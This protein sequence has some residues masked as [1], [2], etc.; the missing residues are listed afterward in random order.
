M[1]QKVIYY[2]TFLFIFFLTNEVFS[3]PWMDN[4]KKDNPPQIKDNYN[5]YDIQKSFYEYVSGKDTTKKGLGWKQFK[6]WE[7]FWSQRVY[8]SGNFPA[9]DQ[10]YNELKS[11]QRV[12]GVD[13]NKN[14]IQSAANWISLGPST[15]PGGYAGLGRI[16][17]VQ[18]DPNNS[19]T[20][21]IGAASG[22]LWKSTNG[23]TTWSTTTDELG[24]IGVTDVIVDKNN[25]NIVY[26]ATGDGDA[27]DAYSIGVMKSTDGGNTWNTTGLNWTQ[28]Q[29]RTISRLL[30]DPSSSNILYAGGSSGI[31]KTTDAGANWTQ[32]FS[33]MSVKDMEFK[34]GNSSVIYASGVYIYRSTDAGANWSQLTNGLPSSAQRVALGVSPANS[35]Y[36]YALMSNSSSGFLGLYR[37]TDS[38]NSWTTQATTPNL[39]GWNSNGGDSG[40]QGW[41]DLCIAVDQSNAN[42][43]Y[44]GGVNIWKSTDGGVNW[45]INAHWWGD[46]VPAVHADQHN[47]WFAPGTNRLYNGCDGGVY[48]TTNGGTNWN[49]IGSGLTIT[50][51][52]RIG[53]SQTNQNVWIAGAQD[54]G[55]KN[56]VSSTWQDVIGGDGMEC[57]VDN[58]TT[59][60]QYG[61]L[62]YGEIL[63]STDG[64]NN[65]YDWVSPSSFS[66]EAGSWV[67]PYVQ[68][69]INP[70]TIFVG[71]RNIYKTT[72]RG[73]SWTKIS[74]FASTSTL[75][76]LDVDPDNG[77]FIY[78]SHGTDLMMSTDGGS[79][80]NTKTLPSGL[81]LTYLA[82]KNTTPL[83]IYGAFS[84]Y[85]SGNKVFYSTDG[86][87]TWNNLSY[88]LPNLPANTIMY[89][90]NTSRLYVG[91]DIGVYYLDPGQTTWKDFN[92]N[93][94]NVVV[95]EIDYQPSFAKM[96]IATYGR[97]IWE[98]SIFSGNA[99]SLS[100]PLNNATYVSQIPTLTWQ[101]IDLADKYEIMIADNNQF[102]NPIV[103]RTDVV[104][105]SYT[106]A[107]YEKLASN[108]TYYWKVRAINDNAYGLWSNSVAPTYIFTTAPDLPNQIALL[109][110]ANNSINIAINGNVT[111]QSDPKS[112]T[113]KLQIATD[114]NFTNLIYNQTGIATTSFA[115][116]SLV[117][118]T[119][120]YWRVCG[121]NADG[122]GPWSS[123]WNF[124]TIPN[125]PGQV[126]LLTPANNSINI[127]INGNV[128]WQAESNSTTYKMQIATDANFTN[129]V[130]NQTGIATTSFAYSSLVNNTKYYWRVL[131]TNAGGDGPWSAVWNFT[132]IQQV[133]A[134][135]TL[136]LPLSASKIYSKNVTLEWNSAVRAD[137]YRLQVA[138]DA[139]FTNILYNLTDLTTLTNPLSNLS[140]GTYY[141]RVLGTNTG[142]DGPWSAVWNFKIEVLIPTKVVLTSPADNSVNMPTNTALTWQSATN[143]TTYDLLV[144]TDN[145]F[146]NIV[147]NQTGI[148]ATNYN[149]TGLAIQKQYFWKVR[150]VHPSNAGEWSDAWSFATINSMFTLN[151]SDKITCKGNDVEIGTKDEEGNIITATGGS[152]NFTYTWSPS[153]LLHNANTGNPTYFN[154]NT[155][156]AF[157]VTVKDNVSGI[158]KSG[159]VKVSISNGPLIIMPLFK[160][161]VVGQ[162]INLDNQVT[163]ISGG[164]PPYTR[165]WQDNQGNT[166]SNVVVTPPLGLNNYFLTATDLNSCSATKKLAIIVTNHKD[167]I[168][169]DNVALSPQGN[170]AIIAFPNPVAN[171]LNFYTITQEDMPL[172]VQ[173]SNLDGKNVYSQQNENLSSK[174]TVDLSNLSAGTYFL[175][176]SN[177]QE[178]TVFKFIKK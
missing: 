97:G 47:L 36:I 152:G 121:T 126:T 67:T 9:A 110:P 15:S 46:G 127:A 109:T 34:P 138:T 70:Q 40:G 52:Y 74:S 75:N 95:S 57:I 137:K 30:M 43:I 99:V 71:Y 108:K 142:G 141:W 169:E 134:M 59:T 76:V 2:L 81:Y 8:P 115:Y 51:F 37:S 28:A 68:H 96:K 39:L 84:G 103:H 113:Y 150:G 128:T 176:V 92:T 58:S 82:I 83:T 61:E 3:Q 41:Y 62:Y 112:I 21:Y 90:K 168:N 148:T 160:V 144:A 106:V 94:P 120:Y 66:N 50:Q 27:G 145:N 163:S 143:A 91:T 13:K 156:A 42:I 69:P 56:Y 63:R 117:N 88:N 1:K 162:S 164:T 101:A 146:T 167:L 4:L 139:N 116:S 24:S 78:A 111:W 171:I 161:I 35:N 49:W 26:I 159:T 14:K 5:F 102:D 114:A 154:P 79:T 32:I 6:R 129:I 10:T 107:D 136:K 147:Q 133:P 172:N 153:N 170:I 73:A 22:G 54:N 25:S 125:P 130:Y 72:D 93:L 86:G 177:G 178:Q 87:S 16:N 60:Y 118:N 38:G 85:S 132:T 174:Q 122:D 31:Y 48:N 65:F 98:T 44:T 80:W 149:L 158:Q 100:T 165:I 18:E 45:A 53:A 104:S 89:Q 135:V 119:K 105:N 157:S 131:G 55:T 77:T 140:N 33:S 124:T 7:W 17:A 175:K 155:F 123:V 151:L 166:L 11:F 19:S 173:I 20:I 23:G 29:S 12:N 64:G